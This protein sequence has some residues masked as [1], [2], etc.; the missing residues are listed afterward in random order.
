MDKTIWKDIQDLE[1]SLTEL[2]DTVD[3]ALTNQMIKECVP[4][5]EAWEKTLSDA[6]QHYLA[7][8]LRIG[9]TTLVLHKLRKHAMRED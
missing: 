5:I 3:A 7:T 1:Q 2:V 4:H 6:D 9:H 8:L